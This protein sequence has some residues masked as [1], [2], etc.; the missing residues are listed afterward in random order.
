MGGPVWKLSWTLRPPAKYIGSMSKERV[1]QSAATSQR[2]GIQTTQ[3]CS[4]SGWLFH[5]KREH[6]F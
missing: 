3:K 2:T 6:A 1:N 5:A 4:V